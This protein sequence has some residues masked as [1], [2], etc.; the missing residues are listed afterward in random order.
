MR[1]LDYHE[2]GIDE[3]MWIWKMAFMTYFSIMLQHSLRERE[4][5]ELQKKKKNPVR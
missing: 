4:T 1:W 5:G 2:C 3:Q